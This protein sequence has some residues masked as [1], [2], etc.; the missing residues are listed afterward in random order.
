MGF[1]FISVG[2]LLSALQPSIYTVS[3]SDEPQILIR[4]A[5]KN[6][7]ILVIEACAFFILNEYAPSV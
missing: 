7:L 6:T 3:M 2:I 5:V 4:G 1:S